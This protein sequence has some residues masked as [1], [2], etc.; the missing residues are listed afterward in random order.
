M[1]KI[2][3]P[4]QLATMKQQVIDGLC[5]GKRLHQIQAEH[6]ISMWNVYTWR[7]NDPAF[8][9]DYARARKIGALYTEDIIRNIA[10]GG[11]RSSNDVKRD[12]I[13]VDVE[14]RFLRSSVPEIYGDKQL[15]GSDPDNPIPQPQ[16]TSPDE[17]AKLLMFKLAEQKN[18]KKHD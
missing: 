17:L 12:K 2:Y 9:L 13:M 16:A 15:I 5:V 8:K 4:E 14:M 7:D 6:G 18:G 11:D 3:S 10:S 1:P